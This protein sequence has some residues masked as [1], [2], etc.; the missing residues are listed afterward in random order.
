MSDIPRIDKIYPEY[1]PDGH[2]I[3][4]GGWEVWAKG[5]G[6]HRED[7]PAVINPDG[8]IDW[9]L[10]G[11]WYSAFEDWLEANT[12]IT[13]SQKVLLKLKYG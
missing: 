7:G 9:H 3:D 12:Y 1:I 4:A 8:G 13:D 11:L 5:G 10:D 6:Y 2:W